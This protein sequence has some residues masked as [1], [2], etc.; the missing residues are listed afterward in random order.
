MN[1]TL[2]PD[3]VTTERFKLQAYSA[4]LRLDLRQAENQ[5]Q[6]E[7]I[8]RFSSR[9]L[10]VHIS[11]REKIFLFHFGTAVFFNVAVAQHK[12]YLD[13]LNLVPINSRARQD[14]DDIAQDDFAVQVDPNS[15]ISVGFSGAT[16]PDLAIPR[17][18]LVAQVLAQSNS[19]ELT[20]WQVEELLNESEEMTKLLSKRGWVPRR[21]DRLMRFLG[22]ALATNHQIINQLRLLTDPDRTWDSE[23]FANLFTG[24]LR[25]FDIEKRHGRIEKML[26]LAADVTKLV[27]EIGQ[28]NRAELLEMIIIALIFFEVIRPM[29]W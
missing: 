21:Q 27:L 16:L 12:N 11:E 8:E 28:S 20:E 5:L 18:Q 1:S 2:K 29:F 3:N 15:P 17:L 22:Q 4:P 26:D 25:T 10:I 24:L 9:S 23:E 7:S 13:K 14:P 6:G 19:L